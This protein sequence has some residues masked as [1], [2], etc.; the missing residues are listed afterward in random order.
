LKSFSPFKFPFR[1]QSP[2]KLSLEI[3][4]FYFFP[5]GI[6]IGPPFYLGNGSRNFWVSTF[7]NHFLA[8]KY[9][10]L[11]ADSVKMWGSYRGLNLFL[12]N[13]YIGRCP[14]F[15]IVPSFLT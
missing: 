2:S 15:F 14:L 9:F 5:K 8:E 13:P 4:N 7:F 1:T 3:S 11:G 12:S 10:P 6:L